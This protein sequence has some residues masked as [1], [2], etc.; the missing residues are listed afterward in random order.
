MRRWLAVLAV[1]LGLTA[2][3]ARGADEG[4]A[5]RRAAQERLE[6]A[7]DL[8]SR[9]RAVL[10]RARSRQDSGDFAGAAETVE[11]W[12]QGGDD[13]AHHLLL[14]N[15]GLSQLSLG[16]AAAAHEAFARA[17]S[18][19]PEYARAWLRRGE[20][21][22]QTGDLA[23]AETSLAR[24]WDLLPDRPLDL[25]YSLA[26]IQI[27][28]DRPAA[29]LARM[30]TVFAQAPDSLRLDWYRAA[31]A[32]GQ[33][34]GQS[35]RVKPHVERMLT[36]A[37]SDPEAWDLAYRFA[38]ASDDYRAAASYLT[39]KGY[40][41][42]L[43]AGEERQLGDLCAAL[44]VPRQ[45]AEH[46]AAALNRGGGDP[47]DRE[48][49]AA[50][51]L[52]A[53]EPDRARAALQAGLAA[54]ETAR[55]Y[56][57]L[58]DLEFRQGDHAAALAAFGRACEMDPARGRDWLMRGWSAVELGRNAEARKHL[59]RAREFPDYAANAAR[60]LARLDSAP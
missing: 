26:T 40:L 24:A 42:T 28:R 41:T 12:L 21:A 17:C 9:A 18:A 47:A 51:W 59:E 50:A 57:L 19:A 43:T 32:A 34:A 55:L 25:A 1:M 30:E 7:D 60:L 20:A 48:R 44:D 56:S 22:Y 5:A 29:A 45:A 52:A 39:V 10:F 2:V 16:D 33:T 53:H 15:L 35:A 49:L 3:A 23:D 58:G 38:A 8:G 14:F 37:P 11:T 27:Q 36:L 4:V 13:R 46:Y 54:G 31:V 6:S